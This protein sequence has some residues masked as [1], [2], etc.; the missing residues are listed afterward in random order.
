MRGSSLSLAAGAVAAMLAGVSAPAAVLVTTEDGNGADTHVANDGQQAQTTN[1]GSAT[2]NNVRAIQDVRARIGMLRFDLSGVS[3]PVSDVQLQLEL[4]EST[5]TRTW[6]IYGLNDDGQSADTTA[7]NWSET[8]VAFNNAPGFDQT[9]SGVNTGNY[10]FDLSQVTAL[11]TMSVA[12]GVGLNTSDTS[13]AF[14]AFI[15][16]AIANPNNKLVT[17]FISFDGGQ[18]STDTNPNWSF[19]SKEHATAVAPTLL[20]TIPEPASLAL[21]SLGGLALLARRRA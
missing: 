13:A 9:T 3:S 2:S 21:V 12:A 14:D 17:L 4:T 10:T 19:A 18:T 15:N 7:D 6:T 11:T 8:L 20:A 1:H 5:R 16:A